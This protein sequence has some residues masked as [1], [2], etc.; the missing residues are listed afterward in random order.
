MKDILQTDVPEVS[1][2]YSPDGDGFPQ[3]PCPVE[4]PQNPV[5]PFPEPL[6]SP[7]DPQPFMPVK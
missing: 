2:G 6:P 4:Y 3:F 1:G 7:I 5:G